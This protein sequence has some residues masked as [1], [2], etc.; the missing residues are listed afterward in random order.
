M[1]LTMK[2]ATKNKCAML[3]ICMAICGILSCQI[4]NHSNGEGFKSFS[5]QEYEKAIGKK[6]VKE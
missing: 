6:T 5:V 4:Q 3:M 2:R 1:T